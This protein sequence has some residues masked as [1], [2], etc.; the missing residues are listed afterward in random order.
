VLISQ[1]VSKSPASRAGI[2]K[3][4]ILVSVNSRRIDSPS[5]LTEVVRS[6]KTGQTVSV[7][8]MRNGERRTV[9]VQLAERPDDVDMSD[10]ELQ[11]LRDLP[12]MMD[13][14]FMK[15][16]SRHSGTHTYTIRGP[17]RGRLELRV[18]PQG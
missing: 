13:D 2:R 12:R 4:D 10:H 1:V 3:G 15:E 8:L 14:D 17:S 7:A 5:E 16:M 18:R 6:A 9:S 11:H